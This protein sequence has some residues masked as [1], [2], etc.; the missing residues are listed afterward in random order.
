MWVKVAE[1]KGVISYRKRLKGR[2]IIIEARFEDDLWHV[3]KACQIKG[4]NK[5]V[6]EYKAEDRKEVLSLIE[7]L[8][9][10]KDVPAKSQIVKGNSSQVK[11]HLKRAYKEYDVEKWF[12][13]IN[14]DTKINSVIL[15]YAEDIVIDMIVH[16]FYKGI[17]DSVFKR[18]CKTLNLEEIGASIDVNIY[19]FRDEQHFSRQGKNTVTDT[20][21]IGFEPD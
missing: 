2:T 8:K 12:F 6:K 4:S 15:R 5:V 21:E 11:V 14:N 3:Y 13:T 19:F 17:E 20:V 18:I 16:E 9:N 1:D 10:E 7:K